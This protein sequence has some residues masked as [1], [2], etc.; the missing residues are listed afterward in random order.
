MRILSIEKA[1]GV[2][3]DL[4]STARLSAKYLLIMRKAMKGNDWGIK[5]VRKGA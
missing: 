1:F 5:K 4:E 3:E 2:I